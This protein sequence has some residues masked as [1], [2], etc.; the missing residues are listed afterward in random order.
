MGN[1]ETVAAASSHGPGYI[2]T[3]PDQTIGQTVFESRRNTRRG[4]DR[5]ICVDINNGRCSPARPH[6]PPG[7]RKILNY[8]CRNIPG[9]SKA[10]PLLSLV[11]RIVFLCPQPPADRKGRPSVDN[12]AAVNIGTALTWTDP[13]IIGHILHLDSLN[14]SLLSHIA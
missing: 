13:Y 12:K 9:S 6:P 4:G 1:Q 3:S 5:D 7:G 10:L 11:D 8:V 2:P 14:F